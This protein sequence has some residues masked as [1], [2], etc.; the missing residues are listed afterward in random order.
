MAPGLLII[1]IIMI[2]RLFP[3]VLFPCCLL[4]TNSLSAEPVSGA[5]V[6]KEMNLAR[7]NPAA[8]AAFL[9][10]IR[11]HS[12]GRVFVL[13]GQTKV[14]AHEGFR[15]MDEAIN[16]LRSASPVQ[17]LTLSPGLCARRCRPLR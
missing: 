2:K 9:E 8:Y 5:A 3:L 11:S 10:E 6:I 13:P 12:D 16:F 14:P 7:Q 4:L 15:A 1:T 17:P